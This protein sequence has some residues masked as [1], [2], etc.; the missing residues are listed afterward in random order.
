MTWV[1]GSLTS[2]Q[3][4]TTSDAAAAVVAY[5]SEAWQ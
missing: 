1:P 4:Q 5:K 3:N 2:C